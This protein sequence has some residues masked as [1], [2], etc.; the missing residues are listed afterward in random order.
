MVVVLV[1]AL[2]GSLIRIDADDEVARAVAVGA[3]PRFRRHYLA[4][5]QGAVSLT[6]GLM[7]GAVGLIAI[8]WLDLGAGTGPGT[9]VPWPELAVVSL[10]M[11]LVVFAV[12]WIVVRSKAVRPVRRPA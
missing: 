12:T 4:S 8:F 9:G 11:P 1:A 6:A 7:S 2:I 3:S 5:A 10:G